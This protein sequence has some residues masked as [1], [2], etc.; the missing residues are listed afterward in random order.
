MARV[1]EEVIERLKREVSVVRLVE[2]SGVKLGKRGA[3]LVGLCPFHDDREPSLVVSPL[4]N[5]W[6]CLGA[7][8]QGGSVI[9]WVMRRDRVSFRRAVEALRAELAPVAPVASA[10]ISPP[11]FAYS[12]AADD[13]DL[14]QQ[15][16]TYY[17]DTLLGSPEALAYLEKRGIADPAAVEHWQ[18]GYANRTL[19]Y[20]FPGKRWKLGGEVRGRLTKLGILR[21]SGHE[22]FNGCL[23]IPV[24]DLE[25]K[26]VEIYGRKINPKLHERVA[27][28]LYLP[29]PHRGVWN[30]EAFADSKEVILCEALIDALTFWCAGF[31]HVTAAY[32]VNGFTQEHFEALK[33]YGIERVLIAYDRDDAG[34]RAAEA[35]AKK[36]GAEGIGCFRVVFP[37]GMDANDYARK[38][39]PARESLGLALRSAEWM[40][41]PTKRPTVAVAVE[42]PAPPRAAGAVPNVAKISAPPASPKASGPLRSLPRP[43]GAV[44][45]VK[46]AAAVASSPAT[47]A[48][49]SSAPQL[50]APARTGGEIAPPAPSLA[51][52]PPATPEGPLAPAELPGLAPEAS[53]PPT[54]P[55][56][57]PAAAAE[58]ELPAPGEPWE[59]TL[60]DRRYRVRGLEKNLSYEQ[61]R[62][63]LRVSRGEGFF[64]DSLDLVSAR[65]RG[66]F[67]RQAAVDLGVKE[68]VLKKD[69][70]KVHFHLEELQDAL[71]KKTLQPQ[72]PKAPPMTAE[73]TQEALA[74]L[75]DPRLV[76]RILEDFARCGVVGEETNKL[77]GYLAAVSRKL[78]D[79]LAVTVQSSSAAGKSALL[80]AILA[81][82][83][84]EER[85]SYSAMT[86]QSLF[87]MGERDLAHKVLAVAEE[88][89]AERASYALKLLQSEGELT[90]ASTGK[91]PSTG[92]LVTHE[93]RVEGPVAIFLT[94]TALEV[95]EELLNRCLVLTVDE[96]R[97]QTRAIHR[98]QRERRTLAGYLARQERAAI[99]SRH[100]NA[101]RLLK[102]LPVVNPYA[103]RLTFLDS[104]TRTRR[105][106]EK[107]LTLIEAVTL[108]HQ[109][110]R[111]R[112]TVQQP[113]QQIEVLSVTPE[114]I[115]LANRLAD[116]ALGQS[117]DELPPQTRRLLSALD[118]LVAADGERLK[119]DRAEIRFSRR[120]VCAATG[121]G[122][123]QV[124]L[125]LA[126]LVAMEYLLVHRGSRGQSFVYE[127]IYDG[128][129][130]EG[131]R[132]LVG[133]IDAESLKV[134]GP[135]ADLA[136]SKRGEDAP[137]AGGWRDE[138]TGN[139]PRQVKPFRRPAGESPETPRLGK[140][141]SV[142]VHRRP[143]VPASS[144]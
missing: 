21:D 140:P 127:L 103:P 95:D 34:D 16:V 62:V 10:A 113:M 142:P 2:A 39:T 137:E 20:H 26:I 83:P 124:R 115:A 1:P 11:R 89:G 85:V 77:V 68:E 131:R 94:T 46:A 17:H 35:L 119:V 44:A 70:G 132:F 136:G 14:V 40:A 73:E 36:L 100:R 53:T 57:P 133:L 28:H 43:A 33:A 123:T 143:V 24:F 81:M 23:V 69:L 41:G 29:G 118:R 3:D 111:P 45:A 80:E 121:W 55:Q 104:Q 52:L 128:R 75:E 61:L 54:A 99:L 38:V 96:D 116:E 67:V 91:D 64:L 13:F 4:K 106:H 92:R 5:L 56:A 76:E 107:Y 15:V 93:Y 88:E 48:V 66:Q 32:G 8:R 22:H 59:I 98:F 84:E 78:E 134:A 108:L 105:D 72:G 114:D 63:V 65:Q 6:H 47:S 18:L 141:D 31:R 86:G 19:T 82:V 71:I 120:Q 122:L 7:C 37:R 51:A 87:Y 102:A 109:Y 12:P 97:E 125:H 27:L 138:E 49:R 135:E 74:L 58:P 30:L 79:P 126:R 50:V 110:Q 117:L 60:G 42:A 101:Q 130:E 9:D 90:I 139:N 144:A 25:N 129:G 112:K